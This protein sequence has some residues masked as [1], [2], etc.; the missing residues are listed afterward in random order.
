MSNQIWQSPRSAETCRSRGANAG[1]TSLTTTSA[2][3]ATRSSSE[4][5]R[6]NKSPGPK[7]GDELYGSI[8]PDTRQ[9]R[10]EVQE[11]RQKELE[12]HTQNPP[13]PSGRAYRHPLQHPDGRR[14]LA[15]HLR[16]SQKQRRL[17][18]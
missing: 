9:V 8:N 3:R 4:V 5:G 14:R 1:Q 18:V 12:G 10:V 6:S 2:S 16:T 17:S 11:G 15:W 13:Q 7:V